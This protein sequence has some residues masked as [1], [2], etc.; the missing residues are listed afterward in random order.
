MNDIFRIS[1]VK[2][3]IIS[4]NVSRYDI[5]ELKEGAESGLSEFQRLYAEAYLHGIGVPK[6]PI[7]AYKWLCKAAEER[8]VDKEFYWLGHQN[9]TKAIILKGVLEYYGIG[10][11]PD[12]LNAKSCLE[13][14]VLYGDTFATLNLAII[15]YN[16]G[17]RRIAV[18]KLDQLAQ[19][20]VKDVN[21][22]FFDIE[23]EE[24]IFTHRILSQCYIK[25]KGV[26]K[27]YHLAYMHWLLA[28]EAGDVDAMFN[29]SICYE[30]GIGVEKDLKMAFRYLSIAAENGDVEA[31][32]KIGDYYSNGICVKRSSRKALEYYNYAFFLS[33]LTS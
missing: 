1:V 6:D 10:V 18:K 22:K 21:N 2:P 11:A 8:P 32:Y 4:N 28:A 12:K 24:Y 7:E 9:D 23:T 3:L 31:A 30:Y 16:E 20:F 29:V 26:K 19:R 33:Q 5:K 17:K 25:G 27:N 15:L 13:K 14:A